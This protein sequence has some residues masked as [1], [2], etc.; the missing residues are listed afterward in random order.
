MK[1]K[2]YAMVL[3]ATMLCTALTGCGESGAQANVGAESTIVDDS[4]GESA[5][6]LAGEEAQAETTESVVAEPEQVET[7]YTVAVTSVSDEQIIA[8]DAEGNAYVLALADTL[9]AE[10][11]ALVVEGSVLT[12]TETT[13]ADAEAAV[14]AYI[15]TEDNE[16][17]E[18][19]TL[20]VTAVAA[21]EDE[22]L[23]ASVSDTYFAE[24]APE[25][26]AATIQDADYTVDETDATTMYAKKS[27]NVRAGASTDYEK[28][29]S[30]SWAEEVTVTGVAS[31]GWYQIS[32][33]GVV[34]YVSN[35]YLVETKPEKQVATSNNSTGS[36]SNG[37]AGT[38]S[39][40]TS[41]GV[42]YFS[43]G[44]GSSSDIS[45]YNGGSADTS[46]ETTITGDGGNIEPTICT[47]FVGY[48]NTLRDGRR[49]E[50]KAVATYNVE[51]DDSL[52]ATALERAK[53]IST[54]YGHDGC[55]NCTAEII[56]SSYKSSS[57]EWYQS[58]YDSP[59]HYS[60]MAAQG[61]KI[62]AAY[63]EVNGTYY[64]VVLFDY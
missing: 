5:E 33:N 15:V 35:N 58:F 24:T 4:G 29:G 53:E 22:A 41:N 64:V 54:N 46:S 44:D 43:Y 55:R 49:A 12:V 3:A 45:I 50:G 47:D 36:S 18:A 26:E 27:V 1:S 14:G 42:I 39:G 37:S 32:Y 48:V 13:D 30:L 6:T 34:G 23:A 60:I 8:R 10:E 52:A 16:L 25:A 51:W 19:N 9:S 40:S 56:Q 21:A 28:I 31:T 17:L 38:G 11:A 7:T 63:C 20:N 59:T 62:G 61:S 2:I 57:S